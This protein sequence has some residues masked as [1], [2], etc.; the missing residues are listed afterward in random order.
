LKFGLDE[1]KLV[2]ALDNSPLKQGK[3]VYGT[4][5][6]V[7]SPKILKEKGKVNVILK[8]GMYNDEIK[9]DILENINPDVEFW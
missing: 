6:K 2:S 9:K 5:L 3:R 4:S 1:S 7:E 8:V